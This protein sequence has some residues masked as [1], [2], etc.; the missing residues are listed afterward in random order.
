MASSTPPPKRLA[1]ITS[2][3]F[4]LAN[5][6]GTLI[7]SL[8]AQGVEVFALAPDYDAA[9]RAAVVALGAR[10][11]DYRGSRTG[12]NPVRDLVD[13]LR[14][15]T[16]IRRLSVDASL[17]YFIKPVTFGT[18]AAW[19]AGVP[20]RFAMIEGLGYVFIGAD[21]PQGFG[22]RVLRG[23]VKGL[24]RFALARTEKVF[25]LN[26]EDI[27]EF[28]RSGLVGA[29]KVVKLGA[30]GVDLTRW[31]PAPPVLAPVTFVMTARL[32]REKG[33]VEYA[34]AARMVKSKHPATRFILLGGLD[35]NPGVIA[36]AEAEAWV[37]DGI[38]EWPGHVAVEPWLA[39]ASVYV[40]PSYREGLPRST[41][42]AMAMARPVIT[43]DVPGCRDTVRNGDNGFLVP[44]RDAQALA[45]AMQRFVE[46]PELI[47]PMGRASRAMAE[48][49]FDARRAD[50]LVADT[51]QGRR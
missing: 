8:V 21:A 51:I 18:I 9:T 44:A 36:R 30:I 6:R 27:A 40:L 16:L 13:M 15:A 25:F 41:Q 4:S 35:S 39:Q 42:E 45:A 46:A 29:A 12:L 38:L 10:P 49:R 48:E 19:L 20:R 7:A 28:T 22:R 32:L 33:V 31:R 34:A 2:Q 14:L 3:A 47:A 37:R 24:Y 50:T 17:A 11:V 5:F 23:L 26:D 1:L 43:T